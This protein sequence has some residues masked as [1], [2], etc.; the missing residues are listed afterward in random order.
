MKNINKTI[1]LV[2]LIIT[3]LGITACVQD[4]SF[5]IP[6]NLGTEENEGLI[7]L[8]AKI[9]SG[10]I[11]LQ[12]IA[13]L[14]NNFDQYE[15]I[16]L[17]SEIAIKGYVTSSD[18]TGNFYKE[19]FIQDSPTNPT[20]AIKIVLNQADTY[21]Q[22]NMGREVYIYLKDLYIGETN[23]G[24]DVIT[25]G[26]KFDAL[27]N[28]VLAITDIQIPHHIFRSATTEIIAPV[29]LNLSQITENNIGMF[30]KLINVQFPITLAGKPYAN[31]TDYFDSQ[32]IIESC[33]DSSK[34][35][36][37]SSTFSSFKNIILPTNGKGSIS[38]IINKTYNGSRLVINLNSTKDVVM[39][40]TRCAP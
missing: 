13:E 33:N 27:N 37:E 21:N 31:P 24:D 35:V 17:I 20:S 34:F 15:A 8:L 12:T 23:T 18:E 14:K 32:R 1:L 22:F 19:F 38:G 9:E 2:M 3:N 28:N 5:S 26:G 39:G 29:E 10:E 30:V 4:D 40:T 16:Q 7:K 36:L 25:I 6:K 11:Q